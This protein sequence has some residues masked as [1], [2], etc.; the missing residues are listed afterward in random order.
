MAS[1]IFR[2]PFFLVE[3]W[4]AGF[5]AEGSGLVCLLAKPKCVSPSLRVKFCFSAQRNYFCPDFF[6]GGG[7]SLYP[8]KKLRPAFDPIR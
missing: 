4:I 2:V 7:Q 1:G 3:M 5:Q 6:E 8:L